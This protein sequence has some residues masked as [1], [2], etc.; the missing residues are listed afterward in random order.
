METLESQEEDSGPVPVTP[1]TEQDDQLSIIT[2]EGTGDEQDPAEQDTLV[3]NA[4]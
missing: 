4:E 3:F 1:N 2:E